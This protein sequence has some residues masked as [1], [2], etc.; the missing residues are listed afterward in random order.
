MEEYCEVLK[1]WDLCWKLFENGNNHNH[2]GNNHNQCKRK[3][4]YNID[5]YV[6]QKTVTRCYN[7]GNWK[8][9]EYLYVVITQGTYM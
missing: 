4:K 6:I 7:E 3:M 8:K 1:K 9:T 5:E 2:N